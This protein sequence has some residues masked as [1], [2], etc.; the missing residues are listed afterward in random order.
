MIS[1]D[2]RLYTWVDVEEVLLR[3]QEQGNWPQWLVWARSYWDGLT[4]GI[5]PGYQAQAKDWLREVYESR[6]RISSEKEMSEGLIILES[7][8]E[9]ERILPI[10]FEETQEEPPVP[11]LKPSLSRPGV[12]WSP[13]GDIQ[14]PESLAS[15]LPPVV[16]FH[17][18][19]GGVGRTTHAL[20]LAQAL[21]EDKQQVL[22]VDGDMEAPGISWVFEQRLPNPPVSFADFLALA[23][24]DS[25]PDGKN[26]VQ[27]VADRL[28]SGLI[29]GIYIL[30][31]F[32]S[33]AGFTSLE[34][35]PEH[36]I[37]GAKN[38]FILTDILANLGKNLGVDVVLV[39]L[40]AG[41]SELAALLILDP[42]V[43]RI[44]VTTLSGQAISGTSAILELIGKRA[45]STRDTEP[46]PALIISQVP[47][48]NQHSD[49]VLETEKVLLEA[50]R[51]F[52]SEEAEPLTVITPFAENLLALPRSWED[53]LTRIQRSGI[54]A[55]IRTLI[56]WLP[57]QRGKT[58]QEKIPSL[59]SQRES[60]TNF[61]RNKNFGR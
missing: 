26:A 46:L 48:D 33:N 47:E 35:R 51:S 45:P 23:H 55:K 52:I 53:V 31:S 32:R 16:A 17:S 59:K 7:L 36:L 24:G 54:V 20:A 12:L 18:F 60:L 3:I 49:L 2:I 41:L 11:K 19:K 22:L 10:F 27:L 38:P 8:P 9:N 6:F 61:R 34:I 58:V 40:H 30:P 1:S 28:Q 44:F 25:S 37:Q 56:D 29:D 43:Y 50:A 5:R 15:D 21:T 39:D 14:S 13:G 42:R 57:V 4:I